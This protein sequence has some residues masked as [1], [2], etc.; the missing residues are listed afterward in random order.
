[1]AISIAILAIAS[2]LLGARDVLGV[3]IDEDA[4]RV[5]KENVHLNGLDEQIEIRKGDLL[6]GLD[7]RFSFAA[8]F[9]L[10][11]D[12]I[13]TSSGRETGTGFRPG[14]CPGTR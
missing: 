8:V 6:K 3:D 10:T 12:S 7:R 4:V 13:N 9:S 1:M 2:A 5:A 11:S 14:W